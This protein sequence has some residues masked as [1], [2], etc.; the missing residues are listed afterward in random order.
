[1]SCGLLQDAVGISAYT[2]LNATISELYIGKDLEGSNYG[3]IKVL[4]RY[5]LRGSEENH[6]KLQ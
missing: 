6:E 4:S 5:M 2:A 3:L 1:L